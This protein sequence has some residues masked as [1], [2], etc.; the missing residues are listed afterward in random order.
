ATRAD[1]TVLEFGATANSRIEAVGRGS[2]VREWALSKVTDPRGNFYTVTYQ[3]NTTN[4]D[5][6]PTQ[7]TYNQGN[8]R[9][10][11]YTIELS[12]E[13]RNDVT[14]EDS[15]RARERANGSLHL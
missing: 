3:E 5:Y 13:T 10:R 8:G 1:G 12:Y 11:F 15:R 6:F 4:G 14:P 9:T 7:V 2:A